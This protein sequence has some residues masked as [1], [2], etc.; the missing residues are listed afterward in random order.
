M[1]TQGFK[2]ITVPDYIY[3]EYKETYKKIKKE[4]RHVG[5]NSFTAYITYQI[6]QLLQEHN[7]FSKH[8]RIIELIKIEKN[9]IILHDTRINRIIELQF[10]KSFS[11]LVCIFCNSFKCSH[12]GF[13]YSISKIYE[14]LSS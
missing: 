13:C 3:D 8:K 7:T 2:T 10:K 11:S 12:I 5:V 9:R 14:R 1:T 4:L 6:R